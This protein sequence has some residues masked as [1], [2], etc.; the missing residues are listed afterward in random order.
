[1]ISIQAEVRDGS[2]NNVELRKKGFVPAVFYGPKEDSTPI[3]IKEGDFQKIY[4]EAGESTIITLKEGDNSHES[5]IHD[6][7]FDAITGNTVHVDFYVIEKGKKV[8]VSIP[9]NFIGVSPA[10]K[11][12]GG[13]LVKV[14]HELP[15]K[16]LPKDLPSEIDINLESLVDFESQIKAS[17]LVIGEGVELDVEPDEVIAL[18][19]EPKEEAE[20]E[21]I[22]VD[23]SSIE[24]EEK[25]KKDDESEES[26]E[27]E[28]KE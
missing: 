2:E 23:L 27:G 3:K 12:L 11:N 13:V 20:E 26:T 17:D 19:Q 28:S 25:G 10:E 8:E 18:V 15:I 7:Q 24:V 1:M 14:V 21:P 16:A 5:L 4:E 9:L 22:E 6:V